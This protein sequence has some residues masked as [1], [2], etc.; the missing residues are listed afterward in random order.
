MH[1]NLF[2]QLSTDVHL[3]GFQFFTTINTG[4]INILISCDL[5]QLCVYN[6]FLEVKLLDNFNRYYQIVY[7]FTFLLAHTEYP[8]TYNF[9]QALCVNSSLLF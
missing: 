2:G 7:Q 4:E 5:G 8:E 1:C 9:H 6:K 3:G